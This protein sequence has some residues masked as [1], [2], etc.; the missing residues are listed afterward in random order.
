MAIQIGL[1]DSDSFAPIPLKIGPLGPY[2]VPNDPRGSIFALGNMCFHKP[3][4]DGDL[5]VPLKFC[6]QGGARG[7]LL[8]T[9]LYCLLLL[10]SFNFWLDGIYKNCIYDNVWLSFTREYITVIRDAF[11]CAK[12]SNR[13]PQILTVPILPGIFHSFPCS[14]SEIWVLPVLQLK[15]LSFPYCGPYDS[16][17]VPW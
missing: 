4:S 9:R 5:W 11:L 1:Y 12:I 10:L 2:I 17:F 7:P 14:H 8:P 3:G 15:M 13:R 16:G 6:H